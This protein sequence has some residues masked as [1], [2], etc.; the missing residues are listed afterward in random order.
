MAF[1]AYDVKAEPAGKALDF[2]ETFVPKTQR[3]KGL[4][5]I[6]VDAGFAYAKANQLIVIPSC[7]YIS[8]KYLKGKPELTPLCKM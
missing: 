2:F 7:T 8:G 3:G 1:L 4:A 5:E 6:V